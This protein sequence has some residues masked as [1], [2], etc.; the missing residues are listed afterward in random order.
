MSENRFC[1][2]CGQKVDAGEKFCANCGYQLSEDVEKVEE[3]KSLESSNPTEVSQ[4]TG[5]FSQPN[6][7]NYNRP[8][9]PINKKIMIPVVVL[10]VLIGAYIAGNK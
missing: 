10:V 1:P 9:K 7:N 5:Q 3:N 2:N 4:S 8:K 6:N